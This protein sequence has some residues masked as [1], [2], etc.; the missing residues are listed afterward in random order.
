MTVIFILRNVGCQNIF[1]TETNIS[2]IM[3]VYYIDSLKSCKFFERFFLFTHTILYRYRLINR[4]QSVPVRISGAELVAPHLESALDEPHV[5]PHLF[6][7]CTIASSSVLS[8]GE[9][10]KIPCF[11]HRAP[12]DGRARFATPAPSLSHCGHVYGCLLLFIGFYGYICVSLSV[13]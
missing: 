11:P 4:C 6:H 2:V 12:T 5:S 9:A 8:G 3:Y 13:D 10:R 7:V 1:F